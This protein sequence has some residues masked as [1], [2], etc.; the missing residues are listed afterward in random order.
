MDIPT[1]LAAAM[2]N[3]TNT[4]PTR[5]PKTSIVQPLKSYSWDCSL[6]RSMLVPTDLF[7]LGSPTKAFQK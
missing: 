1:E 3:A 6:R 5:A 2:V 4:T 7:F